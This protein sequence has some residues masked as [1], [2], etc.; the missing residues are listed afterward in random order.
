MKTK[1][2]LLLLL[3]IGLLPT[4]SQII[5]QPSSG[6][7]NGQDNGSETSGK[8]SWVNRDSPTT[9]YGSLNYSLSSPRSSCNVSDYKMYF[10]FD[11]TN[12]PAIVSAV[13][14]GVT[15]I[16]HDNYC[17][18]NC[19]AN[20]YFYRCTSEWDE[21][22]L[23][24]SNLPSEDPTSFYGPINI[25]FPNDLGNKEY[26]ITP[27][28]RFWKENPGLNFGF[29]IYSPTLGCNNASVFFGV[30]TSDD[31]IENERP[32]LKIVNSTT[33]LNHQQTTK[34]TPFPNPFDNRIN[35]DVSNV[36][37]C[38]FTDIKGQMI[39]AKYDASSKQFQTEDF[40]KGVYF[41]HLLASG[42]NSVYKLIKL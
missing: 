27:T 34:S 5:F 29:V 19:N 8:D 26:D 6:A 21:M 1:L 12:L 33:A 23:I 20:F 42:K 35:I 9:N 30:K 3:T 40:P 24:Q 10:K 25:T 22:A 7:N 28:Y 38:Y 37:S 14:F 2:V 41:L 15:H 36:S 11:V 32:Y 18:S 17:Y 16:K 13:Y 4:Q 39:N 31:A